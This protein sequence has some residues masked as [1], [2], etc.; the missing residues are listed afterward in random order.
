MT[1][2]DSKALRK[3]LG[4]FATGVAII[5]CRDGAGA[6]VGLT[7]NSFSA[8]SLH[9]P[10]VLWSLR[11]G[12]PTLAAFA[13]ASHFA[14]NVLAQAQVELSRRFAAPVA[15]RFADG[16]WTDG[17]G[18]APL[19]ADCA[20]TLECTRVSQQDAGDH[21]L[22]VGQVQRIDERALPPLVFQGGRYHALGPAL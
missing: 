18:G 14:V 17:L 3:A 13:V 5:T 7:V 21:V 20:A 10:L 9:P 12:S 15:E 16:P 4:H 19:L 1:A 2:I 22:F 6:P 8:L 11:R